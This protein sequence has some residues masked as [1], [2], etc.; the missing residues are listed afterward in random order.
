M[1]LKV[2]K[3][4]VDKQKRSS[5]FLGLHTVPQILVRERTP[6]FWNKSSPMDAIVLKH[7]Y[8]NAMEFN[9]NFS[10]IFS[11]LIFFYRY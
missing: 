9:M 8:I 11:R 1:A 2:E 6:N 4:H 5:N 3:V 7:T 10:E